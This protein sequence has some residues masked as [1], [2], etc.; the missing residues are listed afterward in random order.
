M[1]IWFGLEN[2]LPTAGMN[3]AE[4]APTSQQS[5]QWPKWGQFYET[6]G[7]AGEAPDMPKAKEL[8]ELNSKWMVSTDDAT[9]A[10]IWQQMLQIHADE[11]FSIGIVSGVMQPVVASGKLK[12]IPAEAVYNWDPGAM[13]G[14]YR[15]DTF[16][17]EK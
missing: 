7:Q 13:F 16:Y 14:I 5:L 6:K 17:Y 15:P 11:T 10:D 12:N 9:R 4:L 1:S 3:P 8:A 2:G